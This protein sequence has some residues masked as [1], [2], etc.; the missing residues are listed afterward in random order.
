M[1]PPRSIFDIAEALK[2]LID[3][4]VL[5]AG[6]EN[7]PPVSDVPLDDIAANVRVQV[8]GLFDAAAQGKSPE[9]WEYAALGSLA[10]AIFAD[11]YAS[12]QR[13]GVCRIPTEENEDDDQRGV[14]PSRWRPRGE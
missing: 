14:V 3:H 1:R 12:D 13:V 2:A 7:A 5:R 10:L 6:R 4:K 9:V 8:Q 11:R